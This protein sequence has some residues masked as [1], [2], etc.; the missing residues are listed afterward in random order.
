M[1][2]SLIIFYSFIANCTFMSQGAVVRPAKATRMCLPEAWEAQH[3]LISMACL[4]V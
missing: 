1:R 2:T 3:A 4:K